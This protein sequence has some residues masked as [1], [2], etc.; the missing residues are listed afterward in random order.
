MKSI[1]LFLIPLLLISTALTC[2]AQEVKTDNEKSVVD[3]EIIEV[4]YFHNTRRCAT[5]EAVESV[6][7]S[8]LEESY[9]EQMKKGTIT[10]QSLN[11]EDDVNK[12]LV[13]QLN[14]SGQ[15]LLFVKNDKK[16][17]L[18]ND[19]FLYARTNPDKFQEKIIKTVD[20]L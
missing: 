20:S 14:V 3:N 1:Y 18:T 16:K 6:T 8:T 10:F 12:S 7:I 2:Q 13:R 17:D 15:T 4:Y 11:I 9:P 5:C 19:A